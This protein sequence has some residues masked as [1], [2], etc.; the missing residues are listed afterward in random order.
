VSNRR[1]RYTSRDEDEVL[2]DEIK[3]RVLRRKAAVTVV[4]F[5]M[6]TSKG[7]KADAL[8]LLEI[9]GLFGKG[10]WPWWITEE[11]EEEPDWSDAKWLTRAHVDSLYSSEQSN[12]G[13]RA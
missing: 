7:T 11:D 10:F 12:G 2:A 9:T 4:D 6:I 3:E 13:G 1:P 8:E 5:A